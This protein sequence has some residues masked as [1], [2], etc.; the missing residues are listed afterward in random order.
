MCR[1]LYISHLSP[2]LLRRGTRNR[3]RS[4]VS[5]LASPASNVFDLAYKRNSFEY[6]EREC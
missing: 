1:D 3:E 2:S 6:A 4:F 5:F